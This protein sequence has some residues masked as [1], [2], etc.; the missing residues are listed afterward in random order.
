M[1][2]VN[3][4]WESGITCFVAVSRAV[5]DNRAQPPC[6]GR[7]L[8]C[9]PVTPSCPACPDALIPRLRCIYPFFVAALQGM[10]G[11]YGKA[12]ADKVLL[13]WFYLRTSTEISRALLVSEG[14]VRKVIKAFERGEQHWSTGQRGQEKQVRRPTPIW[15]LQEVIEMAPVSVRRK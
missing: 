12:L 15:G 14:Y 9:P 4:S 11:A 10:P 6:M 5:C 8:E 7:S 1:F 2:F 13:H 3:G